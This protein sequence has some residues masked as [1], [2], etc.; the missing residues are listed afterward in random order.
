MFRLTPTDTAEKGG[1]RGSG[2]Q[3]REGLIA[4][5]GWREVTVKK[6][7]FLTAIKGNKL[8]WISSGPQVCD[9]DETRMKENKSLLPSKLVLAGVPQYLQ[10]P[11]AGQVES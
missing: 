11:V 6:G 9:N 4:G 1:G 5:T 3:S 8:G 7:G 10:W 2:A